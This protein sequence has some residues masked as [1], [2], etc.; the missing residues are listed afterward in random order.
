LNHIAV[1]TDDLNENP[2][3]YI[4]YRDTYLY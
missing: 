2:I 4:T 3:V 1:L